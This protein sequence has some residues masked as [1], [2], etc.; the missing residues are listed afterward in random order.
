MSIPGKNIP[1]G[2]LADAKALRREGPCCVPE[3]AVELMRGSMSQREGEG[4][5]L[6][7]ALWTVS[8]N[9]TFTGHEMKSYLISFYR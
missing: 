3:R 4:P 2:G 1:G 9:L 8:V 6:G 7:G 5:R